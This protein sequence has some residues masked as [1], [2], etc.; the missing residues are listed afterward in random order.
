[1]GECERAVSV[2]PRTWLHIALT[3][4]ASALLGLAV[5]GNERCVVELDI[6]NDNDGKDELQCSEILFGEMPLFVRVNK[7]LRFAYTTYYTGEYCLSGLT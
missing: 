1:M 3:K 2:A 7:I 4:P 6:T 5:N